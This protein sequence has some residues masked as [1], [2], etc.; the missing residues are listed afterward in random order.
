[1]QCTIIW[2]VDD[3][4]ISLQDPEVVT[5]VIQKLTKVFGNESPLTVRRGKVHDYV[6][7]SLDFSETGKVI[8]SMQ[9]YING[10]L[11]EVPDDM[12]GIATTPAT[13]GLFEIKLA[14]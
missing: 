7:M 8:V 1:L 2:H 6:G 11:S 9:D 5:N 10:I 14:G 13:S 12:G 4:K 3:L